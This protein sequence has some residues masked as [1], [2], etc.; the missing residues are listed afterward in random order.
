VNSAIDNPSL[1]IWSTT[2]PMPRRLRL[3]T[4]F[5]ALCFAI[6]GAALARMLMLE[7]NWL[8]AGA[9]GLVLGGMVLLFA[10]RTAFASV[11]AAGIVSYGFDRRPNLS[12][13]L[14]AAREFTRVRAGMLSGIG[15]GIEPE[16]VTFLH[17]KGLSLRTMTKQ[18]AGL[19]G[20]IVLE[21]L[22]DEDLEA[23]RRLAGGDWAAAPEPP[24]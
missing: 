22:T 15:V 14:S 1:V 17:R 20:Q 3:W 4:C 24:V 7:P 19:G 23:M 8:A 16:A 21:F 10:P 12:F 9:T 18:R 11:D 5:L 6:G 13:A 2:R